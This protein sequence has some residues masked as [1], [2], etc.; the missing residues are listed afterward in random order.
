M[1][2]MQREHLWNPSSY[3]QPSMGLFVANNV[4]SH[5]TT[6]AMG[7]WGSQKENNTDNY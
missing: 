5:T 6:K 1:N 2:S 7:N 4:A 3:F